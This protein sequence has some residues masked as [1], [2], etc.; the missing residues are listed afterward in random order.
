MKP[1]R[2]PMIE[3]MTRRKSSIIAT[4]RLQ[5]FICVHHNGETYVTWAKTKEDA[6]HECEEKSGYGKPWKV[7]A[8][9]AWI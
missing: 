9:P 6:A 8:Y 1:R 3:D 7:L 2:K 4:E 5:N